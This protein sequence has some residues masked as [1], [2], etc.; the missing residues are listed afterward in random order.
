MTIQNFVHFPWSLWRGEWRRFRE[1]G[2]GRCFFHVGCDFLLAYDLDRFW[3]W[4]ATP[5]TRRSRPPVLLGQAIFGK[6]WKNGKRCDHHP[7]HCSSSISFR[8]SD[9]VAKQL[10]FLL[11]HC[12]WVPRTSPK[13]DMIRREQKNNLVIRMLGCQRWRVFLVDLGVRTVCKWLVLGKMRL[14]SRH[15]QGREINGSAWL[16]AFQHRK[17]WKTSK[18]K[19]KINPAERAWLKA[20]ILH[21]VGVLPWPEDEVLR[22]MLLGN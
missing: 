19:L 3:T 11:W 10:P 7:V 12:F 17:E 6:K 2:L 20:R 8:R 9:P 5:P 22:F 4:T 18:S 1:G 14:A 16:I 13:A 21:L 15:A